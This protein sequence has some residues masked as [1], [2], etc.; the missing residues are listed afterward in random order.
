LRARFGPADVRQFLAEAYAAWAAISLEQKFS[1]AAI[2]L[3]GLAHREQEGTASAVLARAREQ[4][5]ADQPHTVLLM[6]PEGNPQHTTSAPDRLRDELKM[7]LRRYSWLRVLDSPVSDAAPVRQALVRTTLQGMD[8]ESDR[9]VILRSIT[10]QS[11]SRQVRNPLYDV[12]QES[13]EMARSEEAENQR[14]LDGIDPGDT[15]WA[16]TFG[17]EVR[18]KLADAQ[19]EVR[20]NESML[21]EIPPFRTEG[22]YSDEL[23][24]EITHTFAYSMRWT[25]AVGDQPPVA[26]AVSDAAAVTEV[27]GNASHGVPVRVP[28]YPSLPRVAENLSLRIAH[29]IGPR[30]AEIGKLIKSECLRLLDEQVRTEN[31]D[32]LAAAS[33]RWACLQTWG[34]EPAEARATETALR[35]AL[36][37]RTG[38]AAG[39]RSQL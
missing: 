19:A 11:G 5:I 3:A 6:P 20:K 22:I 28:Q 18:E 26:F 7:A 29:D 8:V 23:Y 38:P 2:Y 36:G 34:G 12:Y 16:I 9:N 1:G 24:Q 39:V 25:V 4:A 35:R 21:R 30:T 37:L 10:Y 17:R 13:L 31:L 15:V 33:L 14:L 27:A 32:P